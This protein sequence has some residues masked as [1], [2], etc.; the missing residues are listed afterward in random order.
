M[1]VL[2]SSIGPNQ[3]N[4]PT[5]VSLAV[6]VSTSSRRLQF[7]RSASH[8]SPK[9]R[10]RSIHEVQP[11]F[12]ASKA[13]QARERKESGCV[14]FFLIYV[15]FSFF[16]FFFGTKSATLLPS[17]HPSMGKATTHLSPV[18]WQDQS[19]GSRGEE[20]GVNI[21][22]LHS[23]SL[24]QGSSYCPNFNVPLFKNHWRKKIIK[25]HG[26]SHART[27]NGEMQMQHADPI[28]AFAPSSVKR[29]LLTLV[30]K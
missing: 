26:C 18:L 2:T 11:G 17:L 25:N 14:N 8:P 15:S 5:A 1:Y 6:S 29:H 16:F 9:R 19:S 7:R 3:E 10:V 12:T 24:R 28:W 21:N 13:H 23:S 27:E 30:N 20:E 4:A 22:H